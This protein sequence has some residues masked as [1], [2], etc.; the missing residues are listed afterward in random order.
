MLAF[1]RIPSDNSPLGQRVDYTVSSD[2]TATID[3]RI[4]DAGSDALIGVRRFVGVTTATI[5]VSPYLRGDL[6]FVPT[7]GNTGFQTPAG[8]VRVVKVCAMLPGNSASRV[9]APVRRFIPAGE[10]VAAPALVTTMPRHR[11]IAPGECDELTLLIG[12]G[13]RVTVTARTT[14]GEYSRDYTSESGGLVV[15][16]LDTR[17]FPDVESISVDAG[18]CGV[19]LYTLL[20]QPR[21]ARRLAWRSEAGSLEYYTFPSE[22]SV[23]VAVKKVRTQG[24][25]GYAAAATEVEQR[26]VLGSAYETREVLEAL[27]GMV[28]SPEVWLLGPGGA[29]RVDVTTDTAITHCRGEMGNLEIEIRATKPILLPWS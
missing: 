9:E 11:L 21:D 24:G 19:V 26:V 2:S 13:Y 12:A 28:A 5:D 16:R 4:S 25:D 17:E 15:F 3:L 22:R 1:T 6:R 20:A 29:E 8:R 7:T 27:A 14:E 10:V 23:T 18:A